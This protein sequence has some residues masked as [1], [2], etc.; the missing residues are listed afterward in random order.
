MLV[1]V[2]QTVRGLRDDV[3]AVLE[4]AN[5][6]EI[7]R[8]GFRITLM[9]SPNAGK[10]SLLNALAQRDV[11]IVSE[12]PGTTRDVL[13]VSLDIDGV[14][15]I[16]SDT[17]GIRET[18]DEIELQGIHRARMVGESSDLV[19]WLEPVNSEMEPVADRPADSVTV[20]TKADI[21]HKQ[22]GEG[23]EIS[24]VSPGGLD[25]LLEY[26]KERLRTAVAQSGDVLV[27]R[28]RH[29]T[30]LIKVL[31]D[32]D[33]F[34]KECGK[35]LTL[36]A[37]YLRSAGDAIGRLTGRVDVEDLLDVIF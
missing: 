10:S 30:E 11:A 16:L 34:E 13:E 8:N 15:V 5:A 6:G 26:I 9:G 4:S 23:L 27:S 20:L 28:E 14:P 29:R 37:E 3:R 12:R 1:E 21:P 2:K 22:T 31:E 7:I 35:D 32:L 18:S 19:L 33:L 24:S 17:A 36:A 25:E